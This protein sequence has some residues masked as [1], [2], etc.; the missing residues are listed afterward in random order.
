MTFEQRQREQRISML[1]S[2]LEVNPL[3]GLALT[4]LMH[5]QNPD[6]QLY[7]VSFESANYAGAGEH[8]L[9]W[10]YSDSEAMDAATSEAEDYYREQDQSQWEEENEDSDPDDV[11]WASVVGAETLDGSEY[12]QYVEDP[13]QQQAFY[14]VVN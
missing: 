14:Q 9:A 11:V 12:E 5:F 10:A 3:N 8:C 4:E 2:L 6:F 13:K 7:V 1:N